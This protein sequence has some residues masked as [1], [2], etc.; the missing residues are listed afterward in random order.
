MTPLSDQL[1]AN[2]V[3][4]RMMVEGETRL[5]RAHLRALVADMLQQARQAERLEADA[6]A[7]RET[8]RAA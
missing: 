6:A 1:R 5:S 3:L 4:L 2:A 7:R 8:R